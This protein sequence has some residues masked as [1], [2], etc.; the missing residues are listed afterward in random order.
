M[1]PSCALLTGQDEAVN[2]GRQGTAAANYLAPSC[3]LL[4]TLLRQLVNF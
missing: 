1:R 3:L 2:N 4:K